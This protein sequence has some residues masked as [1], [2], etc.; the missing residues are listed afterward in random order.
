MATL[1]AEDVVWTAAGQSPLVGT[2]TDK[3][4]VFGK[5]FAARERSGG[6]LSIEIETVMA[7]DQTLSCYRITLFCTAGA[8]LDAHEIGV[9]AIRG[10]RV[11]EARTTSIE[12]CATGFLRSTSHSTERSTGPVRAGGDTIATVAWRSNPPQPA[13]ALT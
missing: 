12:P 13:K 3:T 6:S 4:D 5:F 11:A 8:Q 10:G 9:Y 2:F 1:L 7:N